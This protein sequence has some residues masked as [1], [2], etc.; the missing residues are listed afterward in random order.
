[1]RRS[2]RTPQSLWRWRATCAGPSWRQT[3]RKEP[4]KNQQGCLGPADCACD[5]GHQDVVACLYERARERVFGGDLSV[6]RDKLPGFSTHSCSF[7]QWGE[8]LYILKTA[9]LPACQGLPV[10]TSA[11]HNHSAAHSTPCRR[12]L[13]Q[14]RYIAFQWASSE[15]WWRNKQTH[16][17]VFIPS[18]L[19]HLSTASSCGPSPFSVLLLLFTLFLSLQSNKQKWT[20]DRLLK[21]CNVKAKQMCFCYLCW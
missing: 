14:S 17:G 5:C 9:P 7:L 10:H 1:M 12:D 18:V 6:V 19:T 16:A 15:L 20:L 21:L 2:R 13:T 3:G 8:R 4:L 11:P